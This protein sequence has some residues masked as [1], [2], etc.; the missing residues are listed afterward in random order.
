MD[1]YDACSITVDEDGKLQGTPEHPYT[2]GFLCP[3]LNH[4]NKFQRITQPRYKSETVSMEEAL[5]ILKEKLKVCEPSSVLHYRGSGNFGLM[6]QVT[7]HVFAGYGATLTKGS[8][9]DGA[10]EAGIIEGRGKNHMLSPEE[11]SKSDVVIFWGRNPHTTNSHLLPFLKNKTIIVIDP[12]RTKIA[13]QADLFLQIKPHGDL[14]FALLLSRFIIIE[15]LE[16]KAFVEAYAEE[17]EDFYELT[18]TVRIKAALE[19]IDLSLGN[20]GDLLELIRGKRMVILPG[21]GIQKYRNGADVMRA[22]DA[23]GALLE[24][25]DVG[26]VIWEAL[27]KGLK[28]HLRQKPTVNLKRQ[29]IFPNLI[30]SLYKGAIHSIRCRTLRVL[31][32]V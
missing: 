26:S 12:V 18:Q 22:I 21:V 20:I 8:L 30:S 25:R 19:A 16:D 6:Q 27:L 17:Y 11:I 31:K 15:E 9:C 3:H 23:V 7:D 10:G 5:T 28:I 24:K 14:Q 1:F 2:Q 32:Q 13:D 4:Y 29:S